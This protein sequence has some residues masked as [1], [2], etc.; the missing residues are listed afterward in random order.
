MRARKAREERM[1]ST[2]RVAF[3]TR[4]KRRRNDTC[5]HICSH[6]HKHVHIHIHQRPDA[7]RTRW[8][9]T[10]TRHD[11]VLLDISDNVRNGRAGYAYK[12]VALIL[13]RMHKRSPCRDIACMYAYCTQAWTVLVFWYA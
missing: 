9:A 13:S 8:E 10:G 2:V 6:A 5:T 11:S 1:R 4:R 3:A 12:C 7:H